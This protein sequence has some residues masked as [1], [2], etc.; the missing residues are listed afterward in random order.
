LLKKGEAVYQAHVAN[1]PRPEVPE[2]LHFDDPT[3]RKE[4][5]RNW[6][7]YRESTEIIREALRAADKEID[8]EQQ[9]GNNSVNLYYSFKQI[10][11][12]NIF[13]TKNPLITP[14][15]QKC[16]PPPAGRRGYLLL[17]RTVQRTP[18]RRRLKPEL[19]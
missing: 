18:R 11:S 15:P 1:Y 9:K 10:F 19:I 2:E 14:C 12:Y 3:L 5:L 8:D 13:N 6:K 4:N 16:Q 7:V 17:Q